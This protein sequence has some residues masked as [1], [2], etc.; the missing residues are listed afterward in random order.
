MRRRLRF[1]PPP[2]SE[3]RAGLHNGPYKAFVI[4]FEDVDADETREIPVS[5]GGLVS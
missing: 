5:S 1:P 2:H 4:R 3:A